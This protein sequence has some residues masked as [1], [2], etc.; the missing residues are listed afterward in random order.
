M[1]FLWLPGRSYRQLRLVRYLEMLE[2]PA[3]WLKGKK[4]LVPDGSQWEGNRGPGP[5]CLG[6]GNSVGRAL[7][8]GSK[9]PTA[10]QEEQHSGAYCSHQPGQLRADF[11]VWARTLLSWHKEGPPLCSELGSN[12]PARELQARARGCPVPSCPRE[13]AAPPS[14]QGALLKLD[15][16]CGQRP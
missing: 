12:S 3:P 2:K 1:S 5:T 4:S 14:R 11:A 7:R 10:S 16:G 13:P 6:S 9:A 8:A 15:P